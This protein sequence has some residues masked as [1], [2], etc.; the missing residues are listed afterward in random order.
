M[1]TIDPLENPQTATGILK[2]LTSELVPVFT[3][4]RINLKKQYLNEKTEI[5]IM[6]PQCTFGKYR[7]NYIYLQ[8]T[9]SGDPVPLSK[10]AKRRVDHSLLRSIRLILVLLHFT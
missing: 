8:N 1:K 9:L 4:V 6:R 10:C 7:F 3:V 5:I 2:Q